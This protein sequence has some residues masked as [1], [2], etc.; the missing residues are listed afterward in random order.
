[1]NLSARNTIQQFFIDSRHLHEADI[2]TRWI[3]N[4]CCVSLTRCIKNSQHN[5][6]Y[7]YHCIAVFMSTCEVVSGKWWKDLANLLHLGD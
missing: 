5:V 7:N 4:S 1:M 3:E 2:N 6:T